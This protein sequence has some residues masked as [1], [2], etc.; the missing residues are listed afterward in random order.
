MFC[1][2]SLFAGTLIILFT[3]IGESSTRSDRIKL[4]E[5]QALT[6]KKGHWT[7][8]RRT[9]PIPQLACVGGTAHCSYQPETVQC[10]NKGWDGVTV[11]WECKAEMDK[12]YAFGQ[13]DIS[14]E[15][16]DHS[17]DSYVYAG[18][19]GL[20]Y[21]INY[22]DSSGK[23]YQP[24]PA[25]QS[26]KQATK[27]GSILAL[28]GFLVLLFL[29]WLFCAG[30]HQVNRAHATPPPAGFMPDY[31]DPPPSY[32]SSSYAHSTENSEGPGFGTGL[33]TG[34]VLGYLAGRNSG[35]SS[36]TP[37]PRHHYNTRS[38]DSYSPLEPSSE[39]DSSPT[40]MASG[41]ATSKNR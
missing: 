2:N 14:C 40:R 12:K 22:V 3:F 24:P 35:D 29:F 38:R 26:T 10:L 25:Y 20:E 41:F 30:S 15:G 39:R 6:L 31:Q 32:R 28:F 34:S 4:K 23:Y 16:Y 19:C 33:V 21:T 36:N 7:S 17:D 1:L 9:K 8:A 27:E 37:P 5:I 18:S 11:N 13:L